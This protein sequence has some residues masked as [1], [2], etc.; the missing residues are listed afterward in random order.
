MPR[1]FEDLD[2][3]EQYLFIRYLK[4][5]DIDINTADEYEILEEKEALEYLKEYVSI[6]LD[7]ISFYIGRFHESKNLIT[8]KSLEDA[9]KEYDIDEL[10]IE[11]GVGMFLR[12]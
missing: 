1:K 2:Q 6:K 10:F 12:V 4:E 3:D 7:T 5:N 9:M 8:L 11:V